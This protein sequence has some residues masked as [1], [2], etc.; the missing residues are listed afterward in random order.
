MAYPPRVEVVGAYYH[1]NTT[2]VDDTPIFRDELD[3]AHF[4]Q[5][6]EKVLLRA[7]WAL[8]E[9]TVMSTHYHL[10]LR[11]R[12]QTLSSGFQLLN[13]SY[14]RWFNKR[15]GRRGAAWSCRYDSRLLES[16]QHLRESLRYVARNA[17]RAG[18][19]ERPEEWQWCSYGATIDGGASDP[20]IDEDELLTL[21]GAPVS[22]ARQRFREFVE[23]TDRRN[24]RS[25]RILGDVS[26]AA[27]VA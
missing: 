13:G 24:R 6:L 18:I 1:A 10:V 5:L 4:L 20:L 17:P 22:G 16:E 19:C 3:R 7:A 25:Q 14:A 15:Y 26:D 2:A 8:L 23:E 11:L 21:F 12:E 27:L 9:Y